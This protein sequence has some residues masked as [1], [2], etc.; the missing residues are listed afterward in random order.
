MIELR[1]LWLLLL[2]TP[3]DAAV[4]YH[5][6]SRGVY[7][8]PRL[9][10][11]N[12]G[13]GVESTFILVR[14]ILCPHT[15]PFLS[16]FQCIVLVA[17]TGDEYRETKQL[18]E[19]YVLPLMRQEHIR[20]V[21]VGRIGSEKGQYIVLDDSTQPTALLL[22]D[23]RLFTLGNSMEKDGWVPRLGRPHICAQRWKGEPLDWW[24]THNVSQPFGPY[25]G[26]NR[27]EKRRFKDAQDY[28]CK[29][30]DFRA[31]MIDVDQ[32][33]D[34]AIEFLYLTFGVVWHKSCCDHCPFQLEANAVRH[35]QQD[36][37]AGANALW[38]EMSAL[39]LNPRMG[40]FGWDKPMRYKVKSKRGQIKPA[41][42]HSAYA[43]CVKHELTE[44]LEIF[45]RMI[46]EYS[47][48]TVLWVRKIYNNTGTTAKT[49]INAQRSVITLASGSRQTMMA[50][51]ELKAL[52]HQ[53]EVIELAHC[54]RVIV[55]LK[56]DL[57]P[58][59]PELEEFYVL[60]PAS[61][62]DKCG[63]SQAKYENKWE[64]LLNPQLELFTVVT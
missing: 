58:V 46:R 22:H 20:L 6:L 32:S 7:S 33:R 5:L 25:L 48:W 41:V 42:L 28:G 45:H 19:S 4:L 61:I 47:T 53:T 3:M 24:I 55:R 44:V 56:D 63:C 23:E 16:W 35:W 30:F 39:T 52:E 60:A 18:C 59:Y 40:L 1:S 34:D 50:L 9:H 11:F 14:W 12:W 43:V 26:Y 2:Q 37:Q 57:E 13:M 8:S 27:D 54:H 10:I 31:P 21:Q 29:G 15:R 38:R 17:Q 51:L 64:A 36:P 49:Q 62:K